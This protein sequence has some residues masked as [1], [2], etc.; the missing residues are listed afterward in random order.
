[1]NVIQTLGLINS[2]I[3][4]IKPIAIQTEN[5]F[6]YILRKHASTV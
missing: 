1:M 6:M 5:E 3:H 2:A 4:N